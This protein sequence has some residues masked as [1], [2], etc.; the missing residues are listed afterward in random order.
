MM[1]VQVGTA[2]NVQNA[3]VAE[4]SRVVHQGPSLD[5]AGAAFC[6]R[7]YAMHRLVTMALAGDLASDRPVAGKPSP[8]VGA[9]ELADPRLVRHS[10][11]RVHPRVG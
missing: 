2:P 11:V 10:G 6:E 9:H 1:A 4:T 5:A 3:R 8:L 7:E